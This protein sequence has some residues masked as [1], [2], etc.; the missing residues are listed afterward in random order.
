[1]LLACRICNAQNIVP[2]GDFELFYGC[3]QG[4]QSAGNLDSLLY[5][6]NPSTVATPDYFNQ[7]GT[8]PY[9]G[10]PSNILGFQPAYSGVAYCGVWSASILGLSKYREY[11]AVPLL[12][13]LTA[14]SCYYFQMYVSLGNRCMY[15]TDDF[16]AYF[17][18][19]IISGLTHSNALGKSPQVKNPQGNILN[20]TLNWTLI[21]GSFIAA[22]GEIQLIIGNFKKDS[23][24]TVIS[25][26]W[27]A[28][29]NPSAYYYVDNV[30]LIKIS[31]CNTGVN[32][33]KVNSLIKLFP[34][35]MSDKLNV[36]SSSNELLEIIIYDVASRKILQQ[37]FANSVTL[38]IEQLAKGIY[39]YEIRDR[40]GLC[41]KGKVVKD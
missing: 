28:G 31:G 41:K 32:E 34:N 14:D 13:T 11:L 4:F 16:G 33:I 24:T 7:C 26:P 9:V 30:S 3:P 20:D 22:G 36:T 21:S 5:W 10:V 29:Q 38:S 1:M 19:T 27:V 35:P 18:D 17:S 15:A 25:M 8:S 40:N 39:I 2:N 23:N 6:I 12:D 37:K